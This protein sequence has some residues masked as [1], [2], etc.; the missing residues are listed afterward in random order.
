M[1]MGNWLKLLEK[2][3]ENCGMIDKENPKA[4]ETI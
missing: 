3:Q 2:M 4:I 1:L